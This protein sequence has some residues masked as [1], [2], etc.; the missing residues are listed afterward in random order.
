MAVTR[1]A[2]HDVANS[3]PLHDAKEHAALV[4]A[5]KRDGLQSP[6]VLCEGKILDG[7]NRYN[8]C[9]EAGVKIKTVKLPDDKCPYRWVENANDWRRHQGQQARKEARA[10]LAAKEST[11]KS[12]NQPAPTSSNEEVETKTRQQ[13]AK[14][15]DVDLSSLDR[16]KVV[17]TKGHES[18]EKAVTSGTLPLNTAAELVKVV[19]DKEKQAELVS[20]GRAAVKEEVKR[21]NVRLTSSDRKAAEKKAK[22][23]EPVVVQEE[24]VAELTLNTRLDVLLQKYDPIDVLRALIS[25]MNPVEASEAL[26]D[27]NESI[28]RGITYPKKEVGEWIPEKSKLFDVSVDAPTFAE[29]EIADPVTRITLLLAECDKKQK[30]E[31]LNNI[32]KLWDKSQKPSLY[33]EQFEPFWD[34]F[35]DLRKRGKGDAFAAW[36]KAVAKLRTIDPWEQ[37]GTVEE[38]LV[39]RAKDYAR[40]DVGK[41]EYVKGPTPWLNQNSWDDVEAA[42]SDPKSAA[43]KA[44]SQS[45]Y[46]YPETQDVKPGRDKEFSKRVSRLPIVKDDE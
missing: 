23:A 10:I 37:D 17:V 32:K 15:H 2:F 41:G 46:E 6:I 9:L 22:A 40:S 11:A 38:Y 29:P 18:V 5:I 42:W 28:L 36:K 24:P 7:R 3:W 4:A 12:G 45:Q 8:A 30:L 39:Q 27:A 26:Y 16:A 19:P 44:S 1:L 25:K 31:V 34:A 33:D 21:H 13:A 20:Q 14:D 35:P 43:A